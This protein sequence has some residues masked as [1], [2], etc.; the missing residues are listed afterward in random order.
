MLDCVAVFEVPPYAVECAKLNA[1][2]SLCQSELSDC[3][4]GLSALTQAPIPS[5]GNNVPCIQD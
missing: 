3:G 5:R 4:E 1:Y 2:L